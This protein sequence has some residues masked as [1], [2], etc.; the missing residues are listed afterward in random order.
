[1]PTDK[2]GTRADVIADGNTTANRMNPARLYEHYLNATNDQ[3]EREIRAAAKDGLTPA[4]VEHCWNRV[5]Q[6][7]KIIS[8][9]MYDTITSA[10]YGK[11]PQQHIEEIVKAPMHQGIDLFIPT[12]N[13]VSMVDAM[14]QLRNEYP[15]DIGPVVYRG[16]SGNMVK[17]VDDVMIASNYFIMLEKTGSGW[18]AV[19][20]GTLQQHGILAKL[21]RNDKHAR[22]GRVSPTRNLGEDE[23]R[24]VSAVATDNTTAQSLT[25]KFGKTAADGLAVAE[26]MDMANN[27]I[28]HQE[29][30]R[31]LL[32]V[33]EPTNIQTLIDREK[34]PRGGSRSLRFVKHHLEIAGLRLTYRDDMEDPATIYQLGESIG[35][36]SEVDI[37]DEDSEEEDT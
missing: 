3:L 18:S 11:T 33:D 36:D 28:V 2:H 20:S 35:E 29:A 34:F 12:N 22:P 24:L 17:T 5:L 32:T 7:Y 1:M 26:M 6:Y 37:D 13:K 15:V 25:G 21:T 16:R 30:V 4:V 23:T 8:P 31:R 10:R 14:V 19:S 9:H 27:P